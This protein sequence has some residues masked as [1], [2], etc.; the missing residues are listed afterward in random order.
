M[1]TDGQDLAMAD[2][3]PSGLAWLAVFFLGVVYWAFRSRRGD[4]SRRDDATARDDDTEPGQPSAD[5][6]AR[7]PGDHSKS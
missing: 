7:R 1:A 5:G 2:G 6:S 3:V 4:R